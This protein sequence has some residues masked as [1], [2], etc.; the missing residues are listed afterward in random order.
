MP[1]QTE[2]V[3]KFSTKERN[4]TSSSIVAVVL[5]GWQGGGDSGKGG[6]GLGSW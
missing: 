4:F 3:L 5:V 2:S 1:T 6:L